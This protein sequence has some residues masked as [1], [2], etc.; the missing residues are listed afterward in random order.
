M[1]KISQRWYN[2]SAN[3]IMRCI[4]KL[5]ATPGQTPMRNI[6]KMQW[7]CSIEVFRK[8]FSCRR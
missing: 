4:L 3:V 2:I 6:I 8:S 1:F 7:R 5:V